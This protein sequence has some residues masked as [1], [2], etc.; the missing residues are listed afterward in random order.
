MRDATQR[1]AQDKQTRQRLADLE[2]Q[3]AANRKD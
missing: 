1:C 3:V 2:A